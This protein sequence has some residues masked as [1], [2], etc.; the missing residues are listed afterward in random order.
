[1]HQP[2]SL[3]GQTPIGELPA[4]FSRCQLFIGN[5]S[6]A[7]HVAGAVGVPVVGVFGSTDPYGTAPVTPRRTL[8]QRKVACSPCFLRECP[9][10]HR[11]MTRVTVADV[12]AAAVKWLEQPPRG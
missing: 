9:I 10:D 12:H 1:H 4:L 11:C 6:G 5:D 2:I 7:M 8:V 3:V